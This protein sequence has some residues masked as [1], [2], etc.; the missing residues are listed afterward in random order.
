MSAQR[1]RTAAASVMATL[2]LAGCGLAPLPDCESPEILRTVDGLVRE[3]IR[4]DGAAMPALVKEL[5]DRVEMQLIE[6][7]TL[8]RPASGEEVRCAAQLHM[9]MRTDQPNP[10]WRGP[11]PEQRTPIAYR[12]SYNDRGEV[13]VEV[14]P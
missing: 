7:R 3:S 5:E 2:M 9:R 11:P 6:P 14:L 13:W 4:R 1:G 12:L 8:S 10:R